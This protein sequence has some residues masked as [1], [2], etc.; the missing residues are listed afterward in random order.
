MDFLLDKKKAILPI[1]KNGLRKGSSSSVKP[2]DGEEEGW[3]SGC[4]RSLWP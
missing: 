2:W 4:R 1:W 3:R